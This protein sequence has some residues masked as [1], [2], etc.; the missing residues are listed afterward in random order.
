MIKIFCYGS[1]LLTRRL[2]NR[3]GN[4][5][6]I[7]IAQLKNYKL[8]FNKS[9]KDGSGKATPVLVDE[10][11]ETIF[12]IVIEVSEKQKMILDKYEGKN[13][14]YNESRIKVTFNDNTTMDVITYIADKEKIDNNLKPYDWY[15]ALII[16]GAFEHQFPIDYINKIRNMEFIFDMEI[17]RSDENW[18]I[19]KSSLVSKI[20]Q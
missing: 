7:G 17:D 19:I 15:K 10:D 14:G 13:N 20:F 1:N 8:S 6:K 18:E 2:E 12:G 4:F 3:I 9:S 11:T 16:F 5:K